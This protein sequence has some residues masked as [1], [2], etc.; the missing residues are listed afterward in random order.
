[1]FKPYYPAEADRQR[2][3]ELRLQLAVARELVEIHG[4]NLWM[5]SEVGTGTTVKSTLPVDAGLTPRTL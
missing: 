3:P 4:G 2:S 1:M 5:E